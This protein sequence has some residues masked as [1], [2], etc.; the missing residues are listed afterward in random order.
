MDTPLQLDSYFF[1]HIQVTADPQFVPSKNESAPDLRIKVGVE[2][3]DK[4]NLYQVAVEIISQPESDEVRQP[5]TLHLVGIGLFTV[6]PKWP[7]PEKL[8]GIT[9]ASMIY[10]AA[11]EF[12]ITITS[13]GPWGQ[14]MLPTT[15]F[16]KS[17]SD[18]PK[19]DN[20]K[21]PA[22]KQKNR[23]SSQKDT[24]SKANK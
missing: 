10:S 15:S 22:K 6:D 7:E 20:Q 23:A 24:K 11:R 1:P 5:Y 9:G 17:F 18:K 13:R 14:L 21:K 2:R 19:T 3:E 16:I 4:K 8:L 12:L